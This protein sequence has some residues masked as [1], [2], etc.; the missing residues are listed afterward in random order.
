MWAAI[1][2]VGGTLTFIA[3]LTAGALTDLTGS[4][5]PGFALFAVL[6]WSLAVAGSR[7]PEPRPRRL[8]DIRLIPAPVDDDDDDDDG[9]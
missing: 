9:P 8:G 2:T 3:P 4:Y 1:M 7:L 5:L 6:A